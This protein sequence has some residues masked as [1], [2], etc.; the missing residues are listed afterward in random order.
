MHPITD[1]SPL[2]IR[3]PQHK[4]NGT[5]GRRLKDFDIRASVVATLLVLALFLGG[6]LWSTYIQVFTNTWNG[7]PIVSIV[8]QTYE[9]RKLLR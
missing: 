8:R 6:G 9:M 2:Q 5:Y 3:D 1:V 7:K 4:P